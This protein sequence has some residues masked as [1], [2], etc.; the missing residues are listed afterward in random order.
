M[1]FSSSSSSLSASPNVTPLID[2]LLVLLIIFMTIVP[3][4]P[5][6]LASALP[7]P[8][9]KPSPSPEVPPAILQVRYAPQAGLPVSYRLNG[10]DIEADRLQS[11]LRDLRAHSAVATLF[12]AGDARL[13]Y[14]SVVA[15][16][17]SAQQAGFHSI[18]LLSR[19]DLPH[20]QP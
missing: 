3:L 15:A 14:R 13:D 4:S 18:G 7:Q 20:V 11:S 9:T 1:S 16:V 2:V 19:N 5:H 6:G 10:R 12:V 8:A 17:S